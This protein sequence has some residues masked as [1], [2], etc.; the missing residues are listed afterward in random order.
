[1]MLSSHTNNFLR[2]MEISSKAELQGKKYILNFHIGHEKRRR[3][4]DT[5]KFLTYTY[6]PATPSHIMEL[7][8]KKGSVDF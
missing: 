5:F 6:A 7:P 3:A 2:K 8:R 1:M 4:N